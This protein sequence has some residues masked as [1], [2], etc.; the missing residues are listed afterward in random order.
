M[1]FFLFGPS[2]LEANRDEEDTK[3]PHS[4]AGRSQKQVLATG[5]LTKMLCGIRIATFD[6]DHILDCLPIEIDSVEQDCSAIAQSL[7]DAGKSLLDDPKRPAEHIVLPAK[8][9]YRR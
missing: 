1:A 7:F 6:N 9:H 8:I 5:G 2:K 4:K 3:M